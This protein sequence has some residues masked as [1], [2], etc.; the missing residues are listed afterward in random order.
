MA[1][2]F[3]QGMWNTAL[4]FINWMLAL[5]LAFPISLAVGGLIAAAVKPSPGDTSTGFAI[6]AGSFWLFFLVSFLL[7]QT[8]TESLSKVKVTFHPVAEALGSLTFSFGVFLVLAGATLP[9]LVFV[10]LH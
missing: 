2:G 9:L 7:M 6:W 3:N 1:T 10:R 4:M 8:I 5:F